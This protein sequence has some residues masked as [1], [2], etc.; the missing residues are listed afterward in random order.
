MTYEDFKIK[1]SFFMEDKHYKALFV[2]RDVRSGE[3]FNIRKSA[4]ENYYDNKNFLSF[5]INE[6]TWNSQH[7]GSGFWR[8]MCDKYLD[9]NTLSK[10][11]SNVIEA[12]S[13]NPDISLY[14]EK[15]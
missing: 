1:C 8:K 5:L 2:D 10:I 15:I 12:Y 9:I 4:F 6:Y 3:L 14:H 13:E 7:E 11:P